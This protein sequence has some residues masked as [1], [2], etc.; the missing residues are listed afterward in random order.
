[1]IEILRTVRTLK[2]LES[3]FLYTQSL[4]ICIC[5]HDFIVLSLFLTSMYFLIML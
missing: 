1:M 4:D 3:F 5:Y 2:E